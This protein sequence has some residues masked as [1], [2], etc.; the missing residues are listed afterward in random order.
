[1]S[2]EIPKHQILPLMPHKLKY[3]AMTV[4]TKV[5]TDALQHV[6]NNLGTFAQLRPQEEF[7]NVLKNS[8]SKSPIFTHKKISLEIRE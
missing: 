7:Q 4:T 5:A 1:M 2:A 6:N 3:F 8:K